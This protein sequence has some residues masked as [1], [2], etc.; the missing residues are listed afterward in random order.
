MPCAPAPVAGLG[1]GLA[2]AA[3]GAQM[4]HFVA[5]YLC[6]A[7]RRGRFHRSIWEQFSTLIGT[8]AS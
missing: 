5:G 3:F 1:R 6:Y 2:S 4:Q 7:E 8:E